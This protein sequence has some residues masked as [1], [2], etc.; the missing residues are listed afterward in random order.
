MVGYVKSTRH[1]ARSRAVMRR[2]DDHATFMTQYQAM[3]MS[4]DDASRKAFM[5]VKA[6]KRPVARTVI[7]KR[8]Q[9]TRF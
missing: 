3:G 5:M 8:W 7:H 4:R 1:A 9:S 2:L 6:G